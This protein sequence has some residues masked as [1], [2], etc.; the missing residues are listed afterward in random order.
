M[1][2]FKL[3]SPK[4]IDEFLDLEIINQPKINQEFKNINRPVTNQE[5]ELVI[6]SLPAKKKKSRA[7]WTHNII[8]PDFQR[9]S[10]ANI[11]KIFK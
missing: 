8:L 4:E 3:E 11:L 7:R 1:Y 10:G 6:K 9:Q 2:S 5:T